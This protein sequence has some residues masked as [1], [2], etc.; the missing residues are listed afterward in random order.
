MLTRLATKA[1]SYMPEPIRRSFYLRQMRFDQDEVDSVSFR[2][3]T[4][5]WERE[6][7]ARLLHDAYVGRGILPPAS[8]GLRLTAFTLLPTTWTFV[9]VKD[10]EVLGT[11][12]LTED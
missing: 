9:A 7:A 11:I 2:L 4:A 1:V 6:R 3:A 12:A 10:G 8:H 5:P